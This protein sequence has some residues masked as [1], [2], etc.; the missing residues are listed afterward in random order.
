M[1]KVITKKQEQ[2]LINNHI[3]QDKDTLGTTYTRSKPVVKLMV[4]V[5]GNATWLLSELDPETNIA[6][7]LCDLG[8]GTPE[9]GYVSLDELATLGWRLERDRYFTADKTITEYAHEARAMGGIFV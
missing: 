3:A 1:T 4:R 6:F 9:L 2:Q 7:G 8:L 5:G